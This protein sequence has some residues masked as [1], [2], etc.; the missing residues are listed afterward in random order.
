MSHKAKYDNLFER[1]F[2]IIYYYYY[3]YIFLIIG[4]KPY[5]FIKYSRQFIFTSGIL[6][7]CDMQNV[8]NYNRKIKSDGFYDDYFQKSSFVAYEKSC[9]IRLAARGQVMHD[10]VKNTKLTYNENLYFSILQEI[11]L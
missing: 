8:R 1:H 2:N 11:K 10:I 3:S 9:K 4:Y 7:R 5:Y 6:K